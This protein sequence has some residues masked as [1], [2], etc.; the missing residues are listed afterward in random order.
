MRSSQ[1]I[2]DIIVTHLRQ[3]GRPAFR[4]GDAER[5]AYRNAEGLRCAVGCLIP[6]DAYDPIME[7]HSIGTVM[8][9][10]ESKGF[11]D[12]ANEIMRHAELLKRMQLVHDMVHPESW[13][14]KFKLIAE[15]FHLVVPGV[16]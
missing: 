4:D 14:D 16:N 10:A 11:Q 2:F 8:K 5:C 6:E 7:G 13:E 15:E 12:F 3:Q 9:A 1:E